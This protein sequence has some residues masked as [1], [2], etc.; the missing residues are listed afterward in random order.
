MIQ[1]E[2]P[3]SAKALKLET[4]TLWGEGE[5]RGVRISDGRIRISDG[6][7]GLLEFLRDLGEKAGKTGGGGQ[8]TASVCDKMSAFSQGAT[9]ICP[10]CALA[11]V[12]QDLRSCLL[13]GIHCWLLRPEPIAMIFSSGRQQQGPSGQ[14][15]GRCLWQG[16]LALRSSPLWRMRDTRVRVPRLA[17]GGLKFWDC[18]QCPC[19]LKQKET[20]P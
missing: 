1:T 5:W 17:P 10:I 6:V 3:T 13:S 16:R 2:R 9:T 12:R 15:T 20:L 7:R 19:W 8:N 14:E 18:P 4:R 11:V